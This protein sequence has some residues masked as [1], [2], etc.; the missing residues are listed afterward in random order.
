VPAAR[1]SLHQLPP[2]GSLLQWSGRPARARTN[3][4]AASRLGVENERHAAMSGSNSV[5]DRTRWASNWWVFVMDQSP[6]SSPSCMLGRAQMMSLA[7]WA[8]QI[9]CLF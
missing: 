8:G 4:A 3:S 9:V 1:R 6:S 2:A 7:C 5:A